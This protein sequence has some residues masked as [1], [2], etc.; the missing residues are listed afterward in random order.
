[1][2]FRDNRTHIRPW[3]WFYDE[4]DHHSVEM[5]EQKLIVNDREWNIWTWRIR[6]EKLNF[7]FEF[8]LDSILENYDFSLGLKL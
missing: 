3:T 8:L 6:L 7:I 4:F 1:M 2:Q 5:I